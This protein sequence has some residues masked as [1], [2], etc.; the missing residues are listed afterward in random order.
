VQLL[1]Y[2]AYAAI[3]ACFFALGCLLSLIHLHGKT[4]RLEDTIVRIEDG[5]I[6]GAEQFPGDVTTQLL[7]RGPAPGVVLAV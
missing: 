1:Q 4:T 5:L 3:G 7:G 6:R 2:G